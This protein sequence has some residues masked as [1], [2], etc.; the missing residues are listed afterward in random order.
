MGLFNN[1]FK[2]KDEE[3]SSNDQWKSLQSIDDLDMAIEA[4]NETP[5]L[6]FK[7]STRCSISSSALS[8]IERNWKDEET[9]I[10]PYFLDLISYRD[11]SGAIAD[12]LSV[13][14]QSPQMI[15]IKN[16]KA[17]FD[18]SHMDI[19]FNDVVKYAPSKT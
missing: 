10:T 15:I 6:L 16:G 3:N 4:S 12:K 19:N 18:S 9:S 14:H 13:P 8:R 5:V 17:V 2:G 11:V 1:L 7:H